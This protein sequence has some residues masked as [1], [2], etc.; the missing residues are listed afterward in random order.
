MPDS[1]KT[2]EELIK[3]LQELRQEVQSLRN[4]VEDIKKAV[5]G[6]TTTRDNKRT[7]L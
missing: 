4:L 3:E 1:K 5:T 6:K 7:A 2:K